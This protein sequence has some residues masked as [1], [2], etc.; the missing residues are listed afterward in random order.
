MYIHYSYN[1]STCRKV[2]HLICI[3]LNDAMF[4]VWI[5]LALWFW[6]KEKKISMYFHFHYY[7]PS[8]KCKVLPWINFNPL[9]PKLLYAK[10]GPV[11]LAKKMKNVKSGQQWHYSVNGNHGQIL[12][13]DAHLSL[14]Q[15]Q[16]N[17]Y[18]NLPMVTYGSLSVDPCGYTQY[19][20]GPVESTP[21]STNAALMW[22]WYLISIQTKFQK[23]SKIN[24]Q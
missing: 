10:F 17:K 14:W 24:R 16:V 12:I 4:Q 3:N 15:R 23:K 8:E 22:P 7:L 2:C 21:P 1:I 5:K 18:M 11:V 20:C 19:R 6:R 9:H 13:R